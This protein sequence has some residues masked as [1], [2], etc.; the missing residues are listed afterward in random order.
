MHAIASTPA[1][2]HV[3]ARAG[4]ASRAWVVASAM[5]VAL[6]ASIN[7]IAGLQ[8]P[9]QMFWDEGY[10]LTS[11][12]RYEDGRA[13]F[14]THPP[15]GLMLL[16]AGDA[17][18]QPNAAL[19]TSHLGD[20]KHANGEDLPAG[21][22][23]LGMRLASGLAAVATALALFAL[24]LT[25]VRSLPLALLAANQFVFDNA[26]VAHL[27]AAHLDAFQL[28]FIVLSL[29]ALASAVLRPRRAGWREAAIGG[30]GALAMLV[31]LNAAWLL[32]PAMMLVGL[33]AWD[34]RGEGIAAGLIAAS[35]TAVRMLAAGLLAS[36][37]VLSA[38][39]SIGRNMP[40]ET[41]VAGRQ[42]AAFISG[43][44][45]QYL[46]HEITLSPRVLFDA[47]GDYARF[48]STDAAGL[49]LQDGNSST[50]MQWL[51]QWKPI[52]YRWDSDGVHTS[53]VQ[54][55]ANPVGWALATLAPLAAALLLWLPWRRSVDV[56]PSRAIFLLATL[57]VAWIACFTLHAWIASQRLMYLYHA[58]SGLLL[59]FLIAV[60]AWRIAAERWPALQARQAGVLGAFATLH[61]LAFLWWSPLSFHQPLTHAACE[62]RNL[63]LHV[64]ECQP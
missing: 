26:L 17:L 16:A 42:D 32:L 61:L 49:G 63:P 9:A 55:V 44:Y 37:L 10:Y 50:P 34:R 29:W 8:R 38:H 31:K 22:S 57:L 12:Q 19:D 39:V 47:A 3:L 23:L 51:R 40:D 5:L 27:R 25:L 14:G 59:G 53:Y 64:V 36:V 54:L 20:S 56:A 48:M 58:F 46:Q 45:R 52:N 6:L 62:R 60:L 43:A 4:Q 15:L 11:T 30:F 35:K 41:T 28:L 21:Y 33:R 18:L 2:L 13:Q 7:F 1:L 24:A